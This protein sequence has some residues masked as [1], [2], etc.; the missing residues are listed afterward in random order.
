LVQVVVG[1]GCG[2]YQAARWFIHVSDYNRI[3]AQV[4]A[5]AVEITG[6]KRKS[7]SMVINAPP[8]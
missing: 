2:V 5:F 6:E 4:K 1:L 7:V 8:F 3:T